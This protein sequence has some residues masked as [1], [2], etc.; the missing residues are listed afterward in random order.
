MAVNLRKTFSKKKEAL[1][2]PLSLKNNSSKTTLLNT[3]FYRI[4]SETMSVN[5]KERTMP[6]SINLSNQLFLNVL[7]FN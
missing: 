1:L 6:N 3:I 2:L 5:Y 7:L 4:T